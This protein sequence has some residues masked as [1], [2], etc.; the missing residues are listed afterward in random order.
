MSFKTVVRF[1]QYL[2]LL[3]VLRNYV[4]TVCKAPGFKLFNNYSTHDKFPG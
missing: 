4:L 1:I 2:S 3:L